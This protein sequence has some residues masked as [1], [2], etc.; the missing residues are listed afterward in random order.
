MVGIVGWTP[1]PQLNMYLYSVL[2]CE[3][4]TALDF[5]NPSLATE[6]AF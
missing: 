5:G 6:G 1:E 2:A 3:V 4:A